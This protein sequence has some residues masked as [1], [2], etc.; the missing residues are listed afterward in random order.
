M[1]ILKSLSSHGSINCLA[2]GR[3]VHLTLCWKDG[4][5][6][7]PFNDEMH[8]AFSEQQLHIHFPRDHHEAL[9]DLPFWV[10]LR[11]VYLLLFF[12]STSSF[13]ICKDAQVG[14]ASQHSGLYHCSS[15]GV[16]ASS[17]SS[18]GSYCDASLIVMGF[19]LSNNS[20]IACKLSFVAILEFI[21]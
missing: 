4:R 5:N 9:F 15:D 7:C 13:Q 2:S 10:L 21:F 18:M 12:F 16:L 20:K 1:L 11:K 19:I 17:S 3:L 8:Y 14:L 6:D